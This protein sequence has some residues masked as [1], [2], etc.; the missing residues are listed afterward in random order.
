[1]ANK[2]TGGLMKAGVLVAACLIV[3]R[4]ILE[5]SGAP[6]SVNNIFGVAWL[7][8]V[9]P[10][11]FALRIAASGEPGPFKALFKTLLLFGVYTRLMVMASYM[12]AF[13][14]KWQAPRFSLKMGGNV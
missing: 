12:L 10:V 3:V 2:V 5:Q 1:M 6:E 8:L 13:L 4:I 11:L 7:Y 9:F 14:F